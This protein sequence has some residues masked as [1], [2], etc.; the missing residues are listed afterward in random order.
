M[1]L[2]KNCGA[3]VIG[4]AGRQF[5]C[6]AECATDW[7]RKMREQAIDPRLLDIIKDGHK[8]PHHSG[9]KRYCPTCQRLKEF[10][11]SLTGIASAWMADEQKYY[12][13]SRV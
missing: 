1:K 5:L 13:R 12:K 11:D 4:K 3:P 2:C 8:E 10:A 9:W 6:T 7:M